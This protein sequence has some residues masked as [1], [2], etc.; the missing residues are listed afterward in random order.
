MRTFTT[1]I[2]L[3]LF[4]VFVSAQAIEAWASRYSFTTG[5]DNAKAMALD[6][7]C[8]VY[9]TGSSVSGGPGTEDYNTVKYNTF[10]IQQWVKRYNGPAGGVDIGRAIAVDP[11]GYIYVTGSSAVASGYSDCLTIKYDLNGDTLWTARY[12]G[13]GNKN[14]IA[15]AIAVDDSGNVYITGST[16][17]T[18]GTHGIYE[19]YI[20]I[21]YNTSGVQM[22]ASQYNGPGGDF[23]AA[24]SV[25][26]DGSGNVIVTGESGGGSSSSSDPYQD[27]ATVKYS[28][29]GT[30]VWAKRYNGLLTT[31]N[32]QATRVVT[33]NTDNVYVTGRSEG[34]TSYDDY[35]TIKYN[36]AGT[37][38]WTARY[39]GSANDNDEAK[40]LSVD[41]AGNCFV[42]GIAFGG[43]STGFD[44]VT[45]KY[46]T[47]GSESWA[48]TFDLLSTDDDGGYWIEVDTVSNVYVTGYALSASTAKDYVTA[49]YDS[50]GTMLWS[51]NYSNSNAVGSSDIPSC[52]KVDQYG[53]VYVTGMSALD[54]ATVKYSESTGYNAVVAPEIYFNIFPNPGNGLFHMKGAA[55]GSTVDITDNTGRIVYSALY[56]T[57][58][59][60]VQLD[61]GIYIVAVTTPDGIRS[62]AKM[63]IE[64]AK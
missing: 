2:A 59:I 62:T 38:Q 39:N 60:A 20:T 48:R 45:V 34:I 18:V 27:Y 35:L 7:S 53:D 49:K 54:Y 12:N 13:T 44:M 11:A 5:T 50:S 63:V 14:D 9:V 52:L 23:D 3:T 51:I 61:A 40:S 16:E 17:G 1:V 21:K 8:N 56:S 31:A 58:Q 33:D 57:D 19:D 47:S 24:Y 15:Y 43:S 30:L 36:A 55:P 64:N 6:D 26:V 46:N 41:T 37:L 32:D 25:A 22:W 4:P 29:T 28:V 42:T 10:G